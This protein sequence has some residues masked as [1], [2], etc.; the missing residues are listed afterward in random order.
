[1]EIRNVNGPAR[2]LACFLSWLLLMMPL[3]AAAIEEAA[4]EIGVVERFD[5][6]GLIR[7]AEVLALT[8]FEHEDDPLPEALHALG[9]DGYGGLAFRPEH[10]LWRDNA[11][12][13][14][15]Q[16]FHR[17]YLFDRRVEVHV[18]D[19]SE[20]RPIAFSTESF[21]YGEH[22]FAE[23]LPEDLGFAGFRLHYPLNRYDHY[24]EFM[25]FLG[26]SYFRAIG[27]D[28]VYGVSVRG[29]ALNAG[30][31]EEFP[32]FR[33]FWIERP[34]PTATRITVYALLD[35]QSVTGAYRFDIK[36]GWETVV[37]VEARIFT[38][39]EVE[40]LGVAPL[41]SMFWYAENTARPE[42]EQRP[43][44]HDSDGLLMAAGSGELIWRP[45]DNPETLR[46]SAFADINPRGFGLL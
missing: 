2:V 10:A 25:V 14:E 20:P 39:Q 35:G 3:N 13:F 11:L 40:T 31:A 32:F 45:L 46:I 6:D 30:R 12:P 27:Q 43:K 26:A 33:E 1:M 18:L 38:R 41:T 42:W 44:V 37:T 23:D 7:R 9:Y 17:G 24:S 22:G 4:D 5:F 21:D 28:Q 36:P 8:P 19:G 16:F 29:L 34:A 15:V